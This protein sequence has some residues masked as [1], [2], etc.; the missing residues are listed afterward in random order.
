MPVCI[1]K[2]QELKDLSMVS[3]C[4]EIWSSSY[5]ADYNIYLRK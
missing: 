3:W 4:L 1:F 2:Q 5:A